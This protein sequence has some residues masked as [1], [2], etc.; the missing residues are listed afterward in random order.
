MCTF[1][2]A[3]ARELATLEQFLLIFSRNVTVFAYLL[4]ICERYCTVFKSMSDAAAAPPR[5]K[6]PCTSCSP[7]IVTATLIATH[8]QCHVTASPFRYPENF[9]TDDG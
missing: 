8:A 9:L 4:V 1:F 7:R 2:A 3:F 6:P 5:V